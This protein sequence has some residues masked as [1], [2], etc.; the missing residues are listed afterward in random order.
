MT[1]SRLIEILQSLTRV[2]TLLL[3]EG[4]DYSNQST[5]FWSWHHTATKVDDV[6][7]HILQSL[8]N[9]AGVSLEDEVQS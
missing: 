8:N 1:S 4:Q 5:E 7:T 2:H 9:T 3:K 6:M